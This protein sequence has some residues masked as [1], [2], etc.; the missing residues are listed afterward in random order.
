MAAE[1]NREFRSVERCWRII[2]TW[3]SFS[4]QYTGGHVCER[5]TFIIFAG[6]ILAAINDDSIEP[7]ISR[8]RLSVSIFDI[9][10]LRLSNW[11][12]LPVFCWITIA[13]ERTRP[14]LTRS[15]IL[16]F[17]TSQPLSLLSI[18]RSNTAR[19]RNRPSLF[20]Q[21]LIAQTCWS[22][23]ARLARTNRPAFH[24]RLPLLS[25]FLAMEPP[26]PG[27]NL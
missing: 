1:R 12:G 25:N 22:F 5:V 6:R 15:P 26:M 17:T 16:I 24:G 7:A 21:N 4:R 9:Y 18:A 10:S 23:K 11:T 20:S 3:I 8:K 2:L 27:R 19:S 14:P 13:R